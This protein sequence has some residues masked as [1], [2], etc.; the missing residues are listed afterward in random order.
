VGSPVKLSDVPRIETNSPPTL[1]QHSEAILKDLLGYSQDKIA[2]LRQK[3]V[4]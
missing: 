3:K 1:G 2:A 4:I